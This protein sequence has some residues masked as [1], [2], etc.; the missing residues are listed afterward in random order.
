MHIVLVYS[1][2][3][4]STAYYNLTFCTKKISNDRFGFKI[5]HKNANCLFFENTGNVPK[6]LKEEEKPKC[7]FDS[8]EKPP[9]LL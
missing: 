9:N 4:D 2:Y 8:I 3:N 5:H 1:C 7:E 6:F